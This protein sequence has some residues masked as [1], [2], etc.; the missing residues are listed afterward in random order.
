MKQGQKKIF[1]NYYAIISFFIAATFFPSTSFAVVGFDLIDAK[2]NKVLQ[3]ISC[4]VTDIVNIKKYG[5]NLNIRAGLFDRY[6]NRLS[7]ARVAKITFNIFDAK[8]G[9]YRYTHTESVAPYAAYGDNNGNYKSWNIPPVE[10]SYGL[11]AKAY[12]ASGNVIDSS[13]QEC[14]GIVTK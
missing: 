14:F 11:T 12:D 9:P 3:P 13:Y 8:M 10:A 2:T 5:N 6:G 4:Y 7:M 1:S